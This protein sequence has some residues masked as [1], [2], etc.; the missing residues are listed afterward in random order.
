MVASAGSFQSMLTAL[1][2]VAASRQRLLKGFLLVSVGKVWYG[3]G[4]YGSPITGSVLGLFT[5]KVS[6]MGCEHI[7]VIKAD[8]Y[9]LASLAGSTGKSCAWLARFQGGGH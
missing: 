8:L 7:E 5:D 6:F 2:V 1:H 9:L 3:T 4:V